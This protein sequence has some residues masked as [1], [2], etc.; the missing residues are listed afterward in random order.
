MV[1]ACPSL[2][3]GVGHSCMV[4]DKVRMRFSKSGDLRWVSHHDLMRTFERMLRRAAL[5]F[6]STSGFHPKPR[7]IFALSLS[8][9]VLG[10]REV[11]ELELD[12]ELP[13]EEVRSRLARQAPPGLEI[14]DVRRIDPRTVAH[15]VRATYRLRLPAER[16]AGLS[17]RITALLSA[18]ECWVERT[19]PQPRRLDLRPYLLALRLEPEALEM[20]LRVT[21]T[22]T[23]RSD[24][25]L[26]LLGLSDLLDAGGVLER[27]DL[28]IEDETQLTGN[29]E[30]LTEQHEPGVIQRSLMAPPL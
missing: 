3:L 4:R 12:E 30:Q 26:N 8:L 22:G 21:A 25:V 28:E 18:T 29:R 7:L 11:V 14:I 13:P 10:R 9:G 24:E 27:T 5:P 16:T 19:R 23:A 2:A 17:E 1:S 20:D 15:V 6:H